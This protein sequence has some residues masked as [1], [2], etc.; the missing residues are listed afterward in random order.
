MLNPTIGVYATNGTRDGLRVG[1]NVGPCLGTRRRWMLGR[2][3]PS[4]IFLST[5]RSCNRTTSMSS[6]LISLSWFTIR[7]FIYK[8]DTSAHAQGTDPRVA[9][10]AQGELSWIY[11]G[12]WGGSRR[13]DPSGRLKYHSWVYW[14]W[15]FALPAVELL[16]GW[17]GGGNE[18][19]HTELLSRKQ[20]TG[21]ETTFGQL[22]AVLTDGL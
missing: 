1:R 9:L 14:R 17:R 18:A 19:V 16:V 5:F 22:N 7:L 15:S 20:R 3:N 12:A 8:G 4:V 10:G 11:L 13:R 21:F 2:V 6:A